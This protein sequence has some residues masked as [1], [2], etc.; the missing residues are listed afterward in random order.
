MSGFWAVFKQDLSDLS[1][2][3]KKNRPNRSNLAE[4]SLKPLISW[5]V[6]LSG[7]STRVQFRLFSLA[8]PETEFYLSRKRGCSK[9]K[10]EKIFY[11][12]NILLRDGGLK[13]RFW[14][15]NS[16]V[17]NLLFSVIAWHWRRNNPEKVL[18]K[19]KLGS[20]LNSIAEFM[21]GKL[22]VCS[23]HSKWRKFI[24]KK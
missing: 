24:Q 11:P 15:I 6:F 23:P 13:C 16:S 18:F 1:G 3:S 8:V 2:F 12:R 4:K 9:L 21:M 19:C 7:I 5:A 20:L 10:L 17:R 14:T 22:S